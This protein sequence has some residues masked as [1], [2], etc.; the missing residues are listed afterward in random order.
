MVI[1]LHFLVRFL[2]LIL[3]RYVGSLI[4]LYRFGPFLRKP[5]HFGQAM[6][7]PFCAGDLRTHCFTDVDA[8]QWPKSVVLFVYNSYFPPCLC[9]AS[10][11]EYPSW[12]QY[13]GNVL[14]LTQDNECVQTLASSWDSEVWQIYSRLLEPFPLP[15]RTACPREP[16]LL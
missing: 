3:L 6:M 14:W 11:A 4:D 8:S 1:G 16:L 13:L 15:R 10:L 7:G 5:S 12:S 9:Y 2:H